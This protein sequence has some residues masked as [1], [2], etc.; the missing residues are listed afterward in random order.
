MERRTIMESTCMSM[1][2][3]FGLLRWPNGKDHRTAQATP[4]HC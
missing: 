1:D 4:V 2:F 3:S